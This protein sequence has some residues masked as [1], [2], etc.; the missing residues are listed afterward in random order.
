MDNDHFLTPTEVR[1][2]IGSNYTSLGDILGI[3]PD[4]RQNAKEISRLAE[5][6]VV[7]SDYSFAASKVR[8]I[9]YRDV[10]N[11]PRCIYSKK[12]VGEP[13]VPSKLQACVLDQW[14]ESG[15]A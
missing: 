7:D 5:A 4:S 1:T 11:A 2:Y 15:Y 14:T 3:I 6:K 13:N 10:C 9:L 8:A 12:A